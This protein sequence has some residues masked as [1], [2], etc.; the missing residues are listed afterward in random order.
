M[1]GNKID[2]SLKIL[3]IALLLLRF[4]PCLNSIYIINPMRHYK[5]QLV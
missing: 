2:A 1:I 5:L 4:L 3:A